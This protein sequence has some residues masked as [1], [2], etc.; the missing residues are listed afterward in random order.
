MG[1]QIVL[2]SDQH[3]SKLNGLDARLK[4]RFTQ[5]LPLSINQPEKETCESIL[6]MRIEANGL[7]TEDFDEEALSFLAS[8]FGKT[9]VN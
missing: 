4:T 1:K 9:S 7:N 8:R 6:R 3:P 5:G 2:T